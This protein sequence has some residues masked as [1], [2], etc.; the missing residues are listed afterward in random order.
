[1]PSA[2]FDLS[3]KFWNLERKRYS[4]MSLLGDFGGF[5]DGILLI[6]TAIMGYYSSYFFNR[7]VAEE[8]P[9][10]KKRSKKKKHRTALRQPLRDGKL[11]NEAINELHKEASLLHKAK[12]GLSKC[13]PFRK[14]KD[15]ILQ[16]KALERI[17]HQLDIRSFFAMYTNLSLLQDVLLSKEQQLL[18]AHQDKKSLTLYQSDDSDEARVEDDKLPRLEL[19]PEK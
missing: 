16:E 9:V 10:K 1:M 19:L 8:V 14:T 3:D 5:N 2:S 11:S 12:H 13:R 7:K 17:D 15:S 18:L 4:A 6:P